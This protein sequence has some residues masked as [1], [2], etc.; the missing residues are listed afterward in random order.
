MQRLIITSST[1]YQLKI[2][3]LGVEHLVKNILLCFVFLLSSCGNTLQNATDLSATE[4]SNKIVIRYQVIDNVS[5][6]DCNTLAK[7]GLCFDAKIKLKLKEVST[8]QSWRIYFSHMTPIIRDYSDQFNIGRINGDLHF[9]E[10]TKSFEGW[11]GDVLVDIPFKAE[12]WHISEFDSPPNFYLV[13]NTGASHLIDSTRSKLDPDSRQEYLPHMSNFTDSNKQFKRGKADLSEWATAEQLFNRNSQILRSSKDST[14]RIIPKPYSVKLPVALDA[15][16]ENFLNIS[17]GI[18][19]KKNIFQI[20]QTDPAIKRMKRLGVTFDQNK[21]VSIAIVES[22]DIRDDEGYRLIINNEGIRLYASASAGAFYGL[23]SIAALLDTSKMK[24]PFIEV[25]DKPHYSFRGFFLDVAR[26]F[27]NKEFV[28]RLLDQMA[29]YKLNKFHFHLGDD[30]GWRLEIPGLPELTQLGAYRCH[31]LTE[32]DCL[33]PTLGNGPNK[34]NPNNGFYSIDDY[35]YILKQAKIRHIQVIPSFDMPGHSRAAVKAMQFRYRKMVA[36]GKIELAE[37]F[38]LSD[39]NDQS[40]Y[41]SVQYYND[42]TLNVCMESTY[43]FVAKIVDEV[44]L[45]HKQVKMPLTTYHIGADETPG[46]WVDSPICTDFIEKEAI[47][48]SEL[49]SYFIKRVSKMLSSRD[50]QTGGWSDGLTK[51]SKSELPKNIHANA[52][53]PLFWDGHKVAHSMV[54]DDWE[55]VLS[56]PDVT[57]FDFPYE[58]DP[59]ERG[60]Y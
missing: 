4:L 60:Y 40:R 18:N 17:D 11:K 16:T 9:I 53:T 27:R 48:T 15:Q 41:L 10:P 39:K 36:V 31:D 42:N 38:L 43:R 12:F 8:L 28:V 20:N 30:E 13:D 3:W 25:I 14:S 26:N 57:Y 46:A 22:K 35:Q 34:N 54:N 2:G 49:G 51:L 32:K 50:I 1:K 5:A 33:L 59:K 37:E 23:Q 58:A 45:I 55:V 21:S 52:W 29:A 56:L 47:E 24:L 44:A 6:K 7:S 19:I